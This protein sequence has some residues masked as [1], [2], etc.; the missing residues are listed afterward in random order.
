MRLPTRA[1][2]DP[3][4]QSQLQH[5]INIW[6]VAITKQEPT[7]L[8]AGASTRIAVQLRKHARTPDI[9]DDRD[10]EE[11]KLRPRRITLRFRGSRT[12]SSKNGE[13][14]DDDRL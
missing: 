5:P 11:G 13:L 2:G 1:I 9:V 8:C 12:S 7:V 10:H 3:T 6:L 14:R 4:V